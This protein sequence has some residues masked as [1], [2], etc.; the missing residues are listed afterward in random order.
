MLCYGGFCQIKWTSQVIFIFVIYFSMFHFQA[1]KYCLMGE[2]AKTKCSIFVAL[3]QYC[4]NKAF[5]RHFK[6]PCFA[7]V[8]ALEM[9]GQCII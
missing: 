5:E 2:V 4:C 7:S 9:M 1:K 8:I 6:H 3:L